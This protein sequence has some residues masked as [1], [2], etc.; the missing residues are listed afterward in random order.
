MLFKKYIQI[1]NTGQQSEKQHFSW[2][3]EEVCESQEY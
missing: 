2:E 3:D 1:V